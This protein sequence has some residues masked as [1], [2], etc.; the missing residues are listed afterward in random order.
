MFRWRAN[1]P[2]TASFR[3]LQGSAKRRNIEFQLGFDE[4]KSCGHAT[5]YFKGS[6]RQA[7]GLTVD[8]I[9]QSGPYSI[10]NIQVLANAEN[11]RKER[12]RQLEE[13]IRDVDPVTPF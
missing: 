5:G 11:S 9:D 4:F 6:G 2:E 12:M 8:S 3:H 7:D 1:N 13:K 10:D